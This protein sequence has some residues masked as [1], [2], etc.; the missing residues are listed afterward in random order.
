MDRDNPPV[1]RQPGMVTLL[2]GLRL[3]QKEA[4]SIPRNAYRRTLGIIEG[5]VFRRGDKISLDADGGG[6]IWAPR[7]TG[8]VRWRAYPSRIS[9]RMSPVTRSRQAC[10]AT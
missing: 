6:Q 2:G 1:S 3:R 7:D 4:M 10:H 8:D 5:G 9:R